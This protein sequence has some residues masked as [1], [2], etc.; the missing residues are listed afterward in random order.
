MRLYGIEPQTV[1]F[2]WG[3]KIVEVISEAPA[4]INTESMRKLGMASL[5][6]LVEEAE[7]QGFTFVQAVT[8]PDAKTYYSF[9][10]LIF[11][12]QDGNMTMQV[13]IL[14][15]LLTKEAWEV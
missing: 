7:R 11:E 15:N 2:S 3:N 13:V 6:D 14:Y 5:D 10:K 4:E 9:A 1:A 8:V 12:K